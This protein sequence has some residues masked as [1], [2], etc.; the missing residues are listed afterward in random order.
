MAVLDKT[1]ILFGKTGTNT[2]DYKVSLTEEDEAKGNA[3][4]LWEK[5][6]PRNKVG[7]STEFDTNTN[8]VPCELKDNKIVLSPNDDGEVP[9][10]EES[11]VIVI[12]S[13]HIIESTNQLSLNGIS[14]TVDLICFPFQF[15]VGQIKSIVIQQ[16]QGGA[17]LGGVYIAIYAN[18]VPGLAGARLIW[19]SMG[20]NEFT[21]GGVLSFY[22]PA[23]GTCSG[24]EILGYTEVDGKQVPNTFFYI[25]FAAQGM[26]DGGYKLLGLKNS[27]GF[28]LLSNIKGAVNIGKING[29]SINDEF[30]STFD[31]TI[32]TDYTSLIVPH[33]AIEMIV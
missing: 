17:K 27:I 12:D 5:L 22:D 29:V 10:P 20:N 32:D 11:N 16:A 15:A 8:L 4:Y 2:V 30:H 21:D 6:S 31:Y 25:V 18:D 7:I 24:P 3:D 9:T 1:E 23:A 14:N 13:Y 28:Q 19:G 26:S 33:I